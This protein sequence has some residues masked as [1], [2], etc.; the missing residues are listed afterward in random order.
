MTRALIL[1]RTPFQAWLAERVLAEKKI[2]DYDVIYVT[3]HDSEEDRHYF[4]YFEASAERAYY[5][6]VRSSR[7]D[8]FQIWQRKRELS[9]FL[10]QRHYDVVMLSS[11]DE[12][13]F[14]FAASKQRH[15]KVITFDDGTA[16]YN[17]GGLYFVQPLS[18]RGHLSRKL[19]GVPTY[20]LLKS[21][22]ALHYT[23]HPQLPNIVDCSRLRPLKPITVVPTNPEGRVVAFF[24]G[25]PLEVL[26]KS[27]RSIFKDSVRRY[28][29]DYY[30]KHPREDSLIFD[31][32]PMLQKRGRIAEEAILSAAQG[33]PIKIIGWFSTVMFNLSGPGIQKIAL[34]HRD[35]EY[36]RGHSQLA[37]RVGC[38]V[39]EL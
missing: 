24:I 37:R 21:R 34:L 7:I 18:W 13:V 20:D 39:V 26:S 25:A 15:A 16:N 22:I 23:L 9:R 29:I 33:R 4:S 2:S 19:L 10:K 28:K 12:F 32:I 35:A 31:D 11:I 6:I 14:S 27:Q 38:E 36:F 17:V 8:F 1:L 30:V 5:S 3:R